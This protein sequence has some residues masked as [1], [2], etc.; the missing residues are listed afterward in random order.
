MHTVTSESDLCV[1]AERRTDIKHFY[2]RHPLAGVVYNTKPGSTAVLL[3]LGKD[4]QD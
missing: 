3:W 1:S 4:R 2:D